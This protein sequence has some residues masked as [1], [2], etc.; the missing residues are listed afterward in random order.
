MGQCT[1]KETILAY[2]KAAILD[3]LLLDLAAEQKRNTIIINENTEH[4]SKV[5][6][7]AREV[8]D[9]AGVTLSTMT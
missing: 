7:E 2:Q 4:V 9:S 3:K 5:M 1:S 6:K 8:L